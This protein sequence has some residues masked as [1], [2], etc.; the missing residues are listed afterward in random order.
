MSA[1]QKLEQ[2][3][4]SELKG[5]TVI[6]ITNAKRLGSVDDLVLDPQNYQIVGLKFKSGLFSA[7]QTV[8]V[9]AVKSIGEDAVTLQLEAIPPSLPDEPLFQN[10]P[11][12]SQ[13]IGNSVV[14]EDGNHIGEISNI[15]LSL[16]PLMIAGYEIN[17]GTIFSKTHAFEVTPEVHYGEKLV[18][19]PDKLLDAFTPSS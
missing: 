12:V 14:T 13:V 9:L 18:I 5:R 15:R 6:D 11:T 4:W 8:P 17:K 7:T 10:L 19:I 16:Q 3:K 1:N 2:L